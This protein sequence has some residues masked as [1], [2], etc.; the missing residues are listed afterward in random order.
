ML[1]FGATMMPDPPCSRF[2]E[3]VRLAESCGFDNAWT[4][5]SHVLW[6]DG[7]IFLPAALAATSRIALGFCVTNPGTREPTV[8]A[9]YHATLNHMFPGRV[10]MQSR[11]SS[12]VM[13]ERGELPARLPGRLARQTGTEAMPA[14]GDWV[15]LIEAS[16]DAALIASILPRRTALVRKAAGNRTDAQIVAANV[17]TVLITS[18]IVDDVNVRRLERYLALVWESGAAPVVVITKADEA[19]ADTR[20][21][22]LATLTPSAMGAPIIVVSAFDGDG[23]D[24]LRAW[25]VPRRTVAI[26]GS[27]GVG[28]STLVNRLAGSDVMATGEI[29]V[30][31]RGRHTT[32]HREL[33]LL[34]D[35]SLILDTPGMRELQLWNADAGLA[36]AFADV[37]E[38]I[39]SCR[40]A[41]CH[42]EGDPGCAV[43]AALRDGSLDRD[44]FESWQKLTAEQAFLTRRQDGRLAAEERQKW[45]KI[46][47]EGKSRARP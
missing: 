40:F 38:I 23:L 17:D 5:D 44:R 16:D 31:G 29:R 10:V 1:R 41:N 46:G 3:L 22:V 26:I 47:R 19:D 15:A 11:G 7:S 39:S 6:Q 21:H 25:F 45:K 43:D 28:K 35:G 33:L 2:V 8:S 27:S 32:T 36:A 18:S 12:T 13:T 37:D 14:A 9:S 24:E 42:H 30:D 34:P 20:A 4:Y